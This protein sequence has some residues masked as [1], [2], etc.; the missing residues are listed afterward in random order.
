MAKRRKKTRMGRPPRTGVQ[1]YP[2][3]EIIKS[4]QQRREPDA[5][6]TDELMAHRALVVGAGNALD[7]DAGWEIGKLYLLGLLADRHDRDAAARRRDAGERLCK[8]MARY[9]RQLCLPRRP[10]AADMARTDGSVDNADDSDEY[11][12]AMR[13]YQR[14]RDALAARGW[15]VQAATFRAVRDEPGWR[16]DQVI[17]GLDAIAAATGRKSQRAA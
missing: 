15:Q 6:A 13:D 16:V 2:S 1:R 9:E 11:R 7:P 4:Q 12:L 14:C 3:G 10:K 5:G 8:I 17:E